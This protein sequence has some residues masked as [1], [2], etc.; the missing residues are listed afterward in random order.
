MTWDGVDRRRITSIARGERYGK[1]WRV[2][3][4]KRLLLAS[5]A[6]V[7]KD[8]VKDGLH[9]YSLKLDEQ[10]Y[11]FISKSKGESNAG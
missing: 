5:G 8:E 6:M 1:S 3:Q 2:E 9:L 10:T 11:L 7:V 4:F